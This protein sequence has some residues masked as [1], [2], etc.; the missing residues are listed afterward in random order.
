[1]SCVIGHICVVALCWKPKLSR[2]FMY[3]SCFMWILVACYVANLA[4]SFQVCNTV[5]NKNFVFSGFNGFL[6][7]MTEMSWE[8]ESLYPVV[9]AHIHNAFLMHRN[10]YFNVWDP[11]FLLWVFTCCMCG[12]RDTGLAY[13]SNSGVVPDLLLQVIFDCTICMMKVCCPLLVPFFSQ[14]FCCD[15]TLVVVNK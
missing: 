1:V 6:E 4:Y 8:Y 12:I 14:W 15:Q 10:N 5:Q 9:P 7:N 11:H 3:A 13:V 2:L